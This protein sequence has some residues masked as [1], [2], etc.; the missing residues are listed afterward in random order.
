MTK[1]AFYA[2]SLVMIFIGI[3]GFVS[4]GYSL[5]LGQL[6]D[7]PVSCII[8]LIMLSAGILNLFEGPPD[9]AK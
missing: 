8:G 3:M 6:H 9:N 2:L 1:F 4:F 7:E 5:A